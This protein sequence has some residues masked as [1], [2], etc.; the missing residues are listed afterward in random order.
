MSGNDDAND[1]MAEC[2]AC[3]AVVPVDSEDCPGC[4]I[5]FTGVSETSL[6]E[7]G[8]CGALV[9]LE[10][11]ACPQCGVVFVADDVISI[12][13]DWL[14]ATGLAVEDL[15]KR[16]DENNDGVIEAHEFK[17]GLLALNIA[18]LPE[19]QV[20]RLVK[21]LDDDGN[22]VIDLAELESTFAPTDNSP[23]KEVKSEEEE[24]EEA[25]EKDSS[26]EDEESVDEDDSTEDDS[27]E[28]ESSDVEEEAE[29]AAEDDSSEE[30]EESVDED[31]S[32]EDDSSEETAEDDS[33]EGN[34]ESVDEEE[35]PDTPLGRM[36]KNFKDAGY[37]VKEAFE[38]MDVNNDG[39]IDG[40]E[41][42]KALTE[43]GGGTI[44]ENDVSAVMEEL[45][46][47]DNGVITLDELMV[48][49]GVPAEEEEEPEKDENSKEKQKK[50]FP[51]DLQKKLMS[52]KAND[53]FWPI[54]HTLLAVFALLWVLNGMGT[55][56]DGTGGSIEFEEQTVKCDPDLH[57]KCK[58]SLTPLYG[59]QSS[60]P[61]GFYADGIFFMLLGFAGLGG[62][63][64]AHLVLMKAWRVK[65]KGDNEETG[66]DDSDSKKSEDSDDEKEE[67]DDDDEVSEDEDDDDDDEESE[68]E[69]SDDDDD[70]EESE[71]EDDDDDEESEDD[72]DEESEDED[73]DDDEESEDEDDIDVGSRV[74]V[75]VDGE[76]IFGTILSFDDD[77]D[78]VTIEDEETGDEIEAPQDSMFLE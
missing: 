68:D 51:T 11:K 6:G 1:G 64:Y 77:K 38:H 27:S 71:D 60:M 37:G 20:D 4:G 21:A 14:S 40:E 8:A 19:S 16:F 67:S 30:D 28:E 63:L 69:E 56:V 46:L 3:R 36:V 29:E 48:A 34:E 13:G 17:S 26:E 62:S 44:D 52:K 76:E 2:G 75:E 31:D 73:D 78:S 24:A 72:D 41:M 74:G 5:S 33:S 10:S 23:A 53:I 18:D 47:D 70:D 9:P 7:C 45:D 43:F 12:L 22:G 61:A 25:A 49:F 58:N 59:E 15:F 35:I 54:M 42:T 55:F 57:G 65:A 32:T 39:E 50:E 66:E